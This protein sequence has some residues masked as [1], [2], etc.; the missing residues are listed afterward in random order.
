MKQ[1]WKLP[2]YPLLHAASTVLI[3]AAIGSTLAQE[4]TTPRVKAPD[5]AAR[6]LANDAVPKLSALAAEKVVLLN[7]WASWCYPCLLEMPEFEKLHAQFKDQGFTVV[8]VSV[9][10][11]FEPAKA[12]QDEHKFSFPMLFDHKKEATE[13]FF[14]EVVPQ[15]YL[16]GRDGMLIPIPNPKTGKAKLKVND[17]TIWVQPETYDF[18]AE[19]LQR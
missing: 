7:F 10:D 12:F 5:F 16:I 19:V 11:E 14:V 2:K 6:S 17:P 8:A 3:L 15:T 13:R 1:P 9:Y 18:I 4:Q